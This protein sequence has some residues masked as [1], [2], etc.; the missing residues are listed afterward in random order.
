MSVCETVNT[1]TPRPVSPHDPTLPF[2]FNLGASDLAS[3]PH[4]RT[5]LHD[6]TALITVLVLPDLSFRVSVKAIIPV[7][8]MLFCLH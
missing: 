7:L 8:G 1:P 5:I 3:L 4:T 2:C 6:V